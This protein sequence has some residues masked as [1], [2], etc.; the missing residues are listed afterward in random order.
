MVASALLFRTI[1]FRSTT[2]TLM[3]LGLAL[4]LIQN[5]RSLTP[6][7]FQSNGA[8]LPLNSCSTPYIDYRL[9]SGTQAVAWRAG[10]VASLHVAKL[11]GAIDKCRPSALNSEILRNLQEYGDGG[12]L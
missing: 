2:H 3:A 11:H 4:A 8:C 1:S 5:L 7:I 9:F 10:I 6:M 12:A